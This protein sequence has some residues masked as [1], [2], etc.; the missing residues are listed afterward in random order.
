MNFL[1]KSIILALIGGTA[2]ACFHDVD[3]VRRYK[4][5]A[6]Y[7]ENFDE[8]GACI[9]P[10]ASY[11]A[12]NEELLYLKERFPYDSDLA[13][14]HARTKL[15]PGS[16]HFLEGINEF[17]QPLCLIRSDGEQ[18]SPRIVTEMKMHLKSLVIGNHNIDDKFEMI[19]K[20]IANLTEARDQIASNGRGMG[21]NQKA[22]KEIMR[23]EKSILESTQNLYNL[24][25]RHH[26]APCGDGILRIVL[27]TLQEGEHA[28]VY[29]KLVHSLYEE[30]DDPSDYLKAIYAEL[31]LTGG[32]YE[33]ALSLLTSLT[34]RH[35]DPDLPYQDPPTYHS[36]IL[37]H[38]QQYNAAQASDPDWRAQQKLLLREELE[39]FEI[40]L[41]YYDRATPRGWYNFSVHYMHL[42]DYDKSLEYFS[43][44][45]AMSKEQLSEAGISPRPLRTLHQ[46]LADKTGNVELST[47]LLL[48]QQQK[49][50]SKNK[51]ISSFIKACQTSLAR[52]KGKDVGLNQAPLVSAGRVTKKPA[53]P[54]TKDTRSKDE[55][56]TFSTWDSVSSYLPSPP[57]QKGPYS[58]H[59]L[60][61]RGA[62]PLL[63]KRSH[64][65]KAPTHLKEVKQ[66]KKTR[67]PLKKNLFVE[68]VTTNKHAIATFHKLFSKYLP[69]V[70]S[71]KK[72]TVSL[73]EVQS[74]FKALGQNYDPK[75]GKGSHKKGTLKFDKT[76][77]PMDE[78][79]V[80]LTK[81]TYLKPYQIKKLREAFIRAGVVPKD[82]DILKKL[83]GEG[84]L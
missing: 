37:A 79:M 60:S 75:A 51:K 38:F 29:L 22:R 18:F 54:M 61:A 28:G 68:D 20:Y 48:A 46:V 6:L 64:T 7:T 58:D 65:P 33:K 43:K 49:A 1:L 19:S 31:I 80:I 15:V 14:Y 3:L 32:H 24:L 45:S 53:L 34:G 57:L 44:L 30:S 84:Q 69:D 66:E 9:A 8:Q 11:D 67:Q 25:K 26:A 27:D 76:Q 77:T 56:P 47:S 16:P 17:C 63:E 59:G 5:G 71:D 81:A 50:L 40:L 73:H 70:R 2:H 36:M 35:L 10:P 39:V 62:R 55:A 4:S 42:E 83:R 82:P 52:E 23:L 12:L 72:V 74:L 21:Q 13:L 78:Q 41:G